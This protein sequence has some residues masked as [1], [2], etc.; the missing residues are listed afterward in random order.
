[1]A[2]VH[3]F[4]GR[5]IFAHPSPKD[6]SQAEIGRILTEIWSHNPDESGLPTGL[7]EL[8][9]AAIAAHAADRPFEL[10]AA[11]KQMK[12]IDISLTAI[13]CRADWRYWY[14]LAKG[15]LSYVEYPPLMAVRILVVAHK[16]LPPMPASN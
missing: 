13:M 3:E 5:K 2:G 12:H 8:I 1:M 7:K 11:L 6:L 16:P 4:G 14:S 9:T 15:E 10:D